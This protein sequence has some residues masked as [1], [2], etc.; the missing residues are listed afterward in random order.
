MSNVRRQMHQRSIAI[1]VEPGSF[2]RS[3]SV[4]E[5][6]MWVEQWL[7]AFPA[8]REGIHAD[9]Y[10]WHIFSYERY[11][12]SAKAEAQADYQ[13]HLAP[14]YVVI[15]TDRDEGFITTTRPTWCSLRDWLV[16][17]PN[18]AWTMAFTHEDDW[19][20]PFFARNSEYAELDLANRNT[21]LNQSQVS[22]AARKG[23]A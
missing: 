2:E 4:A 23:L 19:L 3:L 10:L 14:E 6:E 20:G 13:S 5:I 8:D 16:F 12:S 21:L 7:S 1:T 17:P 11:P 18:L 9:E 15:S 22:E